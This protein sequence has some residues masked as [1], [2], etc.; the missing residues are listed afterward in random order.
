M[1]ILKAFLLSFSLGAVLCANSIAQEKCEEQIRYFTISGTAEVRVKPDRVTMLVGI[2][3]RSADL[4]ASKNKMGEVIKSIIAYSKKKG[5]EEKNIQTSHIEINPNY[6]YDNDDYTLRLTYYDVNQLLSIILNDV[7]LY[8]Q[9]I[10][11][12]LDM[13]VNTV[14]DIQFTSSEM[15]KYRDQTRL[16]AIQAAKE[17][18]QLLADATGIKLGPIVNVSEDNY[19]YPVYRGG[20]MANSSQNISF[21]SGG[22]EADEGGAAAGM[23]P[24]KTT[25]TLTYQLLD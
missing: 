9:F 5:I 16:Q 18:A 10:Y 2:A 13:G 4:S 17:K 15:R 20:M 7:N 8:N 23:I 25:I 24:I 19:V 14:R 6:S 3:E 1:K 12:L 22:G 11:D 21:D